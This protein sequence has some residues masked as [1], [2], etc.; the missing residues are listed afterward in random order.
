LTGGGQGPGQQWA[1][2]NLLS[3]IATAEKATGDQVSQ[4]YTS[5]DKQRVNDQGKQSEHVPEWPN[6]QAAATG[7]ADH[8]VADQIWRQKQNSTWLVSHHVTDK[9]W[10]EK[11]AWPAGHH[12]A[13]QK[14][15]LWKIN[16][17]RRRQAT[18]SL[19][20]TSSQKTV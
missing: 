3:K 13:D 2:L 17:R 7:S 19:T 8:H 10:Q 18:T 11:S 12:V 20:G 14:N 5:E 6:V 16:T 9:G 1:G 4:L 15:L